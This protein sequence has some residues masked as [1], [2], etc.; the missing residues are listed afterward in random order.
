MISFL[1]SFPKYYT[2][3]LGLAVVAGAK[4]DTQN[5]PTYILWL[6]F[7]YLSIFT[8]TVIFSSFPLS[9]HGCRLSR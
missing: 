9:K 8:Q 3:S 1:S 6:V 7:S 4:G 5:S 2:V